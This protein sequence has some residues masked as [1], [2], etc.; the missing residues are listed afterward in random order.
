[1]N[2]ST[3]QGGGHHLRL[4]ITVQNDVDNIS[5]ISSLS[6]CGDAATSIVSDI[7]MDSCFLISIPDAIPVIVMNSSNSIAIT[8]EATATVPRR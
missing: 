5:A 7:T 4:L 2:E 1:M 6:G 8:Q 3:V